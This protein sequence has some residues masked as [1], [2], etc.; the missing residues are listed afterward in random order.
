MFDILLA[1]YSSNITELYENSYTILFAFDVK[2]LMRSVDKNNFDK[3]LN[4][5]DTI[6]T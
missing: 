4:E 2:H 5:T 1:E 3:C 6:V